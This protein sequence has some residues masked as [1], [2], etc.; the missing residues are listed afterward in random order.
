MRKWIEVQDVKTGVT[1]N[2]DPQGIIALIDYSTAKEPIEKGVYGVI[3]YEDSR[4]V[5]VDEET[6]KKIKNTK[7]WKR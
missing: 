5:R 3:V 7:N 4:T 6:F 2:L 1:F